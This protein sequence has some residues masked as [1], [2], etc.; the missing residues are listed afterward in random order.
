MLLTKRLAAAAV[1]GVA[2]AGA[3]MAAG[4]DALGTEGI[5]AVLD[6]YR[7][8]IA[9]ALDLIAPEVRRQGSRL[10]PRLVEVEWDFIVEVDDSSLSN[11]QARLELRE[12][13]LEA[14]IALKG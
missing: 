14:R 11:E 3:A 7:V 1:L 13:F 9:G 12:M 8:N 6:H 4:K 5:Y 10:L 2:A